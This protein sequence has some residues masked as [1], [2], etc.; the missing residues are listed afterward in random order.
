MF[1]LLIVLQMLKFS[2]YCHPRKTRRTRKRLQPQLQ[3]R[4][5]V[6]EQQQP[7]QRV[8]GMPDGST[9]WAVWAIIVGAELSNPLCLW[10]FKGDEVQWRYKK[11]F[12]TP[13]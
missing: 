9:T 12:F 6:Q 13:F 11:P 5:H 2:Y 3:F 7:Q 10:A 8:Y 4:Q 1:V